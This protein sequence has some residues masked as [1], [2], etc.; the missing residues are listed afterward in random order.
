MCALGGIRQSRSLWRAFLLYTLCCGKV[1]SSPGQPGFECTS[2]SEY[3]AQV[4][5][6]D[7]PASN[8]RNYDCFDSIENLDLSYSVIVDIRNPS[9][10]KQARIPGSVNLPY[11][12]IL[13]VRALKSRN[14]VIVNNGFEKTKPAQLCAFAKAEDFPGIRVLLGGLSSWVSTGRPLTGTLGS[15]TDIYNIEPDLFFQE[16]FLQKVSIIAPKQ[17]G[18]RISKL[19]PP[20]A[21]VHFVTPEESLKNLV[22]SIRT[23]DEK[24]NDVPIVIVGLESVP[25]ELLKA[26]R[27]VFYIDKTIYE[28]EQQY[29]VSSLVSS[30]R[31][32][33]PNRY[34]CGG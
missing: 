18:D 23:G 24:H 6:K 19:L 17:V 9:E 29:R 22:V 32:E 28:L 1:L 3:L 34:R 4:A 8:A 10:Y 7:G 20:D 12:S 15:R 2:E 21:D 31:T 25:L 14:V 30:S 11:S 13:S 5:V 33:I 16:S 26:N 27:Q